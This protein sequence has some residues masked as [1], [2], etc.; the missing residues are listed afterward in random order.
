MLS[1]AQRSRSISSS[2]TVSRDVTDREILR[3]LNPLVT[4]PSLEGRPIGMTSGWIVPSESGATT[5]VDYSGFEFPDMA[6]RLTLPS[7]VAS[8]ATLTRFSVIV[9]WTVERLR[10]GVH[11]HHHEHQQLDHWRGAR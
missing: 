9:G 4:P 6:R 8:M 1:G 3:L 2:L 5:V 11:E 7:K 10:W